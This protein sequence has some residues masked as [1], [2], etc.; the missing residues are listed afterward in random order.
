LANPF[1]F[2]AVTLTAKLNLIGAVPTSIIQDF[3]LKMLTNT[4]DELNTTFHI[5]YLWN[6]IC[7]KLVLTLNRPKYLE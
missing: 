4:Q 5:M 6:M 2:L 1:L 3:W 7:V